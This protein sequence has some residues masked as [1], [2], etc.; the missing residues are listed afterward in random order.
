MNG[1][2]FFFFF[3]SCTQKQEFHSL[4]FL[5]IIVHGYKKTQNNDWILCFI[6]KKMLIPFLIS[7]Q[8]SV[9]SEL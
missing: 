1:K 3:K 7:L 4:T 9:L 6:G 8:L 2:Y 5:S